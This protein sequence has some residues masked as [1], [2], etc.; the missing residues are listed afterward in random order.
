MHIFLYYLHFISSLAKDLKF[1]NK[2]R[3]LLDNYL[4][5]LITSQVWPSV[6]MRRDPRTKE[7]SIDE[8]SRNVVIGFVN[9]IW[10]NE[11]WGQ[12]GRDVIEFE[13]THVV[14]WYNAISHV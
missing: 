9:G 10:V 3:Y 7:E 8:R 2:L 13:V 4:P 12:V 5:Q 11:I 6:K 1:Q 14:N